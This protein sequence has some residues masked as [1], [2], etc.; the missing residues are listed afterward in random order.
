MKRL[1]ASLPALAVMLSL[2][3][4]VFMTLG[5]AAPQTASAQQNWPPKSQDDCPEGMTYVP[6]SGFNGNKA[7]CSMDEEPQ[8]QDDCPDG[9]TF[10]KGTAGS[11][12]VQRNTCTFDNAPPPADEPKSQADCPE[13]TKFH[14]AGSG[15]PA[16]CQGIEP[17]SQDDCPAGTY[18]KKG[19]SGTIMQPNVCVKIPKSQS[20]C[21]A[22]TIF[23]P[24]GGPKGCLLYTSPSPRDS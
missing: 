8:S 2:T 17:Q 13:G 19:Q 7:G 12:G 6:P 22:G 21:P 18:F 3:A 20:D 23:R 14:P 1:F 24:T 15:G 10:K 16:S 5:L 11:G 9:W 4:G